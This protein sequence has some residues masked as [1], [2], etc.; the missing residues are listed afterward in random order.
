MNA[1]LL[2]QTSF[3]YSHSTF[4]HLTEG[5]KGQSMRIHWLLLLCSL[6]NLYSS[7]NDES[8]DMAPTL[9]FEGP[10]AEE[11]T[12]FPQAYNQEERKDSD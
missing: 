8:V 11:T 1:S 5:T 3:K 2:I 7:D 4:D 6:F 9:R 12:S 10:H